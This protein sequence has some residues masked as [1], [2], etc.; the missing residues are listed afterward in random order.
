M[1]IGTSKGA[2]YEDQ[3]HYAQ[4]QWDDS[5]DNNVVKP[6]DVETNKKLENVEQTELGGTPIADK[7][8]FPNNSNPD[9]NFNNRFGNLPPS[10]I[11]ND[12]RKPPEPTPSLARRISYNDDQGANLANHTTP[13]QGVPST[14]WARIMRQPSNI[15]P[16]NDL[17]PEVQPE[18]H[19]ETDSMEQVPFDDPLTHETHGTHTPPAPGTHPDE[20]T[21][22]Q[23]LRWGETQPY[24]QGGMLPHQEQRWS[25]LSRAEY[26]DIER[27]RDSG[28]VSNAD[29]VDDMDDEDY[30]DYRTARGEAVRERFKD[31]EGVVSKGP[32]KLKKEFENKWMGDGWIFQNESGHVG[33]ISSDYREH[34]G[35][36][37]VS[38]LYGITGDVNDFGK[39][40]MRNL[41][42]LLSEQYPDAKYIDGFRVSGAR[43]KA[44]RTGTARMM[45]PSRKDVETPKEKA[46]REYFA[47]YGDDSDLS[48]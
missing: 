26:A 5:Y 47:E 4:S 19:G 22:Q 14:E 20:M 42:S 46:D 30:A 15:V 6:E 11:L 24:G 1:G 45:I 38:G 13:P 36:I 31:S 40:D 28:Y 29:M 44:G 21:D 2:F 48:R 12:L 33:E 17:M 39:K 16:L 34:T 7:M 25:R 10:G 9:S 41:F 18:I 27:Q 37:H 35:T 32:V 8:P 3:F 43:S 23:F